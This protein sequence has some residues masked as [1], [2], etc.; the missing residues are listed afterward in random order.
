MFPAIS[1]RKLQ[2]RLDGCAEIV[3]MHAL[4]SIVSSLADESLLPAHKHSAAPL[5]AVLV[6][7][8]SR[9][10][11]I[12]KSRAYI[13]L[14]LFHLGNRFPQ[15]WRYI[16]RSVFE[17][18]DCDFIVAYEQ[19]ELLALNHSWWF[20]VTSF[21]LPSRK[22]TAPKEAEDEF[23]HFDMLIL[24]A[25]LRHRQEVD[26]LTVALSVN[27]AE[28]A[29][30]DALITCGCCC[31][32]VTFENL[33]AC[34]DGHLICCKCMERYLHELT[35][36]SMNLTGRIPCISTETAC[37]SIY[38]LDMLRMR[39]DRALVDQYEQA[40]AKVNIKQADLPHVQCS[41]CGN[42]EFYVRD[43][44]AVKWIQAIAAE[45]HRALKEVLMELKVP[46]L[47]LFLA[48]SMPPTL[49]LVALFILLYHT[50]NRFRLNSFRR[51]DN[52]VETN[53]TPIDLYRCQ[54]C[55]KIT[56]T[57]CNEVVTEPH[58][59]RA[60]SEED[61]L[62]LAVEKAMTDALVRTCPQC[63]TRLMKSDGCNKI[64]CKCGYSICY[65]CRQDIRQEGYAHFCQHFRAVPGK[66]TK[67]TKCDLWKS[68][69]EEALIYQAA[70]EARQRFNARKK[71]P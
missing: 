4:V 9:G 58:T 54:K 11:S 20:K 12:Y 42:V 55:H 32:D 50:Y 53:D 56:C 19:L 27:E 8:C 57:L 64:V 30:S 17:D 33:V 49:W 39:M 37:T 38:S 13:D 3:C 40:V 21:I 25:K 66:C 71:P 24:D 16:I 60:R 36:G 1:C 43:H 69:D 29:D 68:P 18:C 52:E 51:L 31:N 70:Q 2:A 45:W 23:F 22:R 59:C 26:D 67:C 6:G 62:R 61:Q 35:Y 5:N 15:L 28:Y 65:I 44:V 63:Q 34:D 46:T 10:G 14:A 48:L 41:S 47:F 7:K